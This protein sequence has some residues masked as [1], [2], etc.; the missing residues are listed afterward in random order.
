V[1]F[2]PCCID[3][4]LLIV[5]GDDANKTFGLVYTLNFWFVELLSI[6]TYQSVDGSFLAYQ[7]NAISSIFFLIILGIHILSN[8]QVRAQSYV[9]TPKYLNFGG[10]WYFCVRPARIHIPKTMH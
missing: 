8:F 1:G 7:K 3:D 2:S 5:G 6:C 10:M 9:Y 4:I